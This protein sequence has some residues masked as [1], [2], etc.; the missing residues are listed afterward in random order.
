[1]NIAT[2]NGT[3]TE[4]KREKEREKTESN[5]SNIRL[6]MKYV[7]IRAKENMLPLNAHDP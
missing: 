2:K 3:I 4:M 6:H 7:F 5:Q 1:M